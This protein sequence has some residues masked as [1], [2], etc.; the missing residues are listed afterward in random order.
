MVAIYFLYDVPYPTSQPSSMVA[1][2][3]PTKIYKNSAV[4]EVHYGIFIIFVEVGGNA[5]MLSVTK[6]LLINSS[7]KFRDP[8]FDSAESDAG[9]FLLFLTVNKK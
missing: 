2:Q 5:S 4:Y 8:V 3:G 9:H 6:L 7:I 1:S